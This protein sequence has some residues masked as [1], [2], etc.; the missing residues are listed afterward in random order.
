MKKLSEIRTCLAAESELQDAELHKMEMEQ[1]QDVLLSEVRSWVLKG[2]PPAKHHRK[3]LNR[4]LRTLARLFDQL[5]IREGILGIKRRHNGKEGVRVLLPRV[6]RASIM[7][8]LHDDPL[9]GHLG[10]SKKPGIKYWKRFYWPGVDRDIRSYCETC[11]QCQK[12]EPPSATHG[13]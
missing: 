7:K 1:E 2:R 4:Q 11:V 8:M 6:Y 13:S 9:S 10:L 12:T 3:K 5:T